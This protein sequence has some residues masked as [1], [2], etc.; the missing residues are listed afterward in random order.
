VAVTDAATAGEFSDS[1]GL[2]DCGVDARQR[3]YSRHVK[4]PLDALVA[5][6]ALL[7]LLPLLLLIAVIVRFTMGPGVIFKQERVG[8]GGKR[9]TVYKF[10]SMRPDRRQGEARSSFDGPDR[11]RTHKSRNHPLVTPMGRVLRKLSLDELPQ[12]WN[13]A[14]GDMSLV[15]PR[16][17]L[18]SVVADYQ[19]WQHDRHLVRPGLTGLWQVKARGLGEMHSH[20]EYDIRYVESMSFKTDMKIMLQTPMA[21]FG[22]QSGF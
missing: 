13:V 6:A 4:R 19:P 22:S 7:L 21:V 5:C 14:R 8:L 11:R 2:N 15:G 18:P 9:F 16:P 10:R 12:L 1:V 3:V 17:E 20:T